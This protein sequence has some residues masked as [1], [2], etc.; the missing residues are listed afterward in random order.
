MLCDATINPLTDDLV[1]SVLTLADI[2]RGLSELKITVRH[3]QPP[4]KG[5]NS[6]RKSASRDLDDS[7]HPE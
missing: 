3:D 6:G 2:T 7:R 5:G 1:Q 4:C